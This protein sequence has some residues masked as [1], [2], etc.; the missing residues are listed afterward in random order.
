[1][2]ISL[3]DYSLLHLNIYNFYFNTYYSIKNFGLRNRAIGSTVV[4]DSHNIIVL[5]TND[6]Y[7]CK[8]NPI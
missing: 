4:H 5:G 6:E 3:V 2:S 7:L 1:M 8:I